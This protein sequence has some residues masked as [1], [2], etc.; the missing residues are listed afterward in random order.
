MEPVR[1]AGRLQEQI[2]LHSE[3][4][5]FLDSAIGQLRKDTSAANNDLADYTISIDDKVKKEINDRVA[6]EDKLKD[7]TISLGSDVQQ[8]RTQRAL[9]MSVGQ[10][11]IL[12][13][14]LEKYKDMA[15]DPKLR[16][17]IPLNQ[18]ELDTL[19]EE[20]GKTALVQIEKGAE[21]YDP[22]WYQKWTNSDTTKPLWAKILDLKIIKTT[23]Y[24]VKKVQYERSSNTASVVELIKLGN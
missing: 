13:D 5:D 6:A 9:D 17:Q 16:D 23:D 10:A 1:A 11:T 2:N 21:K 14:Q 8:L 7:T 19:I 15:A 4:I 3:N 24:S 18:K 12:L 22:S 20:L